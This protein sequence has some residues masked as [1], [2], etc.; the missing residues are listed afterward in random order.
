[1][2]GPATP[3]GRAWFWAAA[4][5]AGAL[6]L[7]LALLLDR[8]LLPPPSWE[9]PLE[10]D[11]D[12]RECLPRCTVPLDEGLP[13]SLELHTAAR[14][15]VRL[16]LHVRADDGACLGERDV[17]SGPAAES[18]P[19]KRT[20]ALRAALEGP[21]TFVW[22]S[23]GGTPG[24]QYL[25]IRSRVALPAVP[26]AV[27]GGLFALA[28]LAGLARA[29]RRGDGRGRRR[30]VFAGARL[31]ILLAL[32]VLLAVRAAEGPLELQTVGPV[33]SP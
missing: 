11:A 17:V 25:V 1:M 24:R 4:G 29:G 32:A 33:E 23:L 21:H 14:E 26:L 7:V 27:S 30:A 2:G 8:V 5:L 6:F 13:A 3:D 12:S 20:I 15:P 31:G 18:A 19:A 10:L 22:E 9:G 28:G 16:R